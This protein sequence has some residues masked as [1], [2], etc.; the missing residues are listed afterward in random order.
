MIKPAI[1]FQNHMILQREK[2]IS[3]WGESDPGVTVAITV[4]GQT[5]I[6]IADDKGKWSV[7]LE[8]L[9]TSF[10]ET[11]VVTAENETIEWKDV[12]VGEVWLAAGQSNMEFFMRYDVDFPL[13]KKTCT[14]HNIRFFDYPEVSYL[15]QIDEANYGKNF[16]QWRKATPEDLEWF[17]AVAYYFAKE[18]QG[19]YDCPVGIVGC[20][21]GGTPA[22]AWMSEEAIREGGGQLYLDEYQHAIANLDLASYNVEFENNPASWKVDP[23]LDT[24]SDMLMRGMSFPEIIKTLTGQELDMGTGDFSAQMP[25]VGPKIETRPCGLYE[26]MLCQVAPYGI[27]GVLFYQGESDGDKHPE[28]YETMFPAL[29]RCFRQLW[30]DELPFLFVQLAPF[31]Q[32]MQCIGESYVTIREA[33]H[34]VSQTVSGTGMAV[35]SDIGMEWDIHPKKKQPVGY[36]LA[37]QA[38]AKVYGDDILCEAPTL[39]RLEK[40]DGKLI[41]HFENTSKG[42]YLARNTPDGAEISQNQ[43]G[44]LQLLTDDGYLNTAEITARAQGSTVILEG[45]P[46]QNTSYITAELGCTGWYRVNLYNSAKI[47]AR[48]V[49]IS[50]EVSV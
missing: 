35:I 16:A 9:Y 46:I 27:R 7:T 12:Q 26:S 21:W 32:W 34:L 13:E 39:T 40:S 20:N 30:Q 3:I 41:M 11:V 10:S 38:E 25:V 5:A 36:R 14:N 45:V 42:L 28:L 4:Q 43:L 24:L 37:L 44:G 31:G 49:R 33:Q 47:P 15:G 18:I 22:C 19:K 48:P 2:F 1:L 17:S 8:P 6:D 23:F 50:T 29:I